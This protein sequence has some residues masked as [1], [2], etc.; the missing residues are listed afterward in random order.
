MYTIEREN[1]LLDYKR[2]YIHIHILYKHRVINE[3]YNSK[4]ISL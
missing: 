1:I 4:L 3:T 2:E